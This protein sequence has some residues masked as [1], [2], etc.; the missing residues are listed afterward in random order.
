MK[1]R[2]EKRT[3][4]ETKMYNM[5]Q[6]NIIT[7]IKISNEHSFDLTPRHRHRTNMIS[8]AFRIFSRL[9]PTRMH[10]HSPIFLRIRDCYLYNWRE[11]L[12]QIWC[13]PYPHILELLL[14]SVT[15]SPSF[16]IT[17]ENMRFCGIVFCQLFS[18]HVTQ[19][20]RSMTTTQIEILVIACR[21]CLSRKHSLQ[22][23]P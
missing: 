9:F 13:W 19:Y 23:Y 14:P 11:C 22:F 16:T 5:N 18:C 21:M 6:E 8:D 15:S 10:A 3:W 7:V 12:M 2:S 20:S 4:T 17:A 1:Q